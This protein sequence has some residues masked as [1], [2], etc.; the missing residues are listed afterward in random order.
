M[1]ITFL[2]TFTLSLFD[3]GVCLSFNKGNEVKGIKSKIAK[4]K[5]GPE[6]IL[7]LFLKKIFATY[8]RA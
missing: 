7:R 4:K 8:I 2:K 1:S 6:Q 5:L 3:S